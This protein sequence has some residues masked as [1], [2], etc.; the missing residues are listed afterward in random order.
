MGASSRL[1]RAPRTSSRAATCR[2]PGSTCTS[3]RTASPSGSRCR[4]PTASPRG[5]A[6]SRRFPATAATSP[7]LRRA[8]LW[9]ATPTSPRSVRARPDAHDDEPR[10]L[11]RTPGLDHP[12]DQP[13]TE[14]RVEML[15]RRRAHPRA[16]P[17]REDNGGQPRCVHVLSRNGWGARIRTWDRG[18]KTRC[19]TTWLRPT[20]PSLPGYA[21]LVQSA[22]A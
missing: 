19:L 11:E 1:A 9:R 21:P 22:S 13:P 8:T 5:R 3:W 16:E 4:G 17:S 14:Q 18:T 12:V 20:A 10:R 6:I 15:R 2:T 7:S